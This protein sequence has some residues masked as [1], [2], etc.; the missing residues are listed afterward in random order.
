MC[1][2]FLTYDELVAV[3]GVVFIVHHKDKN[4][5]RLD[6]DLCVNLCCAL[7]L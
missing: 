1:C 5:L 2:R 3:H 4:T 7:L 6:F